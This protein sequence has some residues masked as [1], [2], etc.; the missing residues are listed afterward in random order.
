MT[1]INDRL[2][3]NQLEHVLLEIVYHAGRLDI[4]GNGSFHDVVPPYLINNAAQVLGLPEPKN[5]DKKA[6][7]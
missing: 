3:I 1:D 7:P 5:P 6:Q 2:R 4:H